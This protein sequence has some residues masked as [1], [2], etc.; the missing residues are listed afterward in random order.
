VCSTPSKLR[1][2][3]NSN[4]SRLWTI[5]VSDIKTRPVT[6]EYA[7]GFDRIFGKRD[8]ARGVW[9]QHPKTGEM[10]RAEDYTAPTPEAKDAPIMAGRFYENNAIRTDTDK[11]RDVGSRRKY[12]E[13][14]KETGYTHASD[15][16]NEWKAKAEKRESVRNG[17][18]PSK[19]RREALEKAFYK[20]QKP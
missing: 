15:Y 6:A 11:L 18:L 8:P 5:T 16:T 13:Y 20:I 9:V 10:I 7:D 4:S 12:R 1:K 3:T 14:L 2:H 19:T 17:K